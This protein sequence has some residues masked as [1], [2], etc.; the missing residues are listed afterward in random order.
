MFSGKKWKKHRKIVT[1]AFHFKNLENFVG[2]FNAAGE[3]LVKKLRNEI[4][5]ESFDIFPFL[6]LYALDVISGEKAVV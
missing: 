4:G 3:V 6:S 1:P 5:K 2:V